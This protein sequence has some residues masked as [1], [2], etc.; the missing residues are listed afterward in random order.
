MELEIKTKIATDGDSYYIDTPIGNQTF[1]MEMDM[2]DWMDQTIWFNVYM[3]LYNKRSQISSN[4][5]HVKMTGSNPMETVAVALKCFKKL[6]REV[7]WA[8]NSKYNIVISCT[9]LN[10]R[11]RD[12]YYKVLSR[13]GYKYGRDPKDGT[14]W[15]FR[16]WKKGESIL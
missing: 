4:E 12:A 13:W 16:K 11:R 9:W 8:Y 6:Q 7:L 15:I 5:S 3:T 2:F 1:H 10:N 14:K